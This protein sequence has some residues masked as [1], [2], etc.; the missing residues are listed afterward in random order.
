MKIFAVYLMLLFSPILLFSQ[1]ANYDE[2]KMPAYKLPELLRLKNGKEVKSSKV[3]MKKRRPEILADF[4]NEMFGKIPRTLKITSSKVLEESNKAFDG[5]ATRKQIRLTVKKGD[6]EFNIGLLLY[7]PNSTNPAPV[8]VGYNFNGN[9]TVCDDP[10][11]LLTESWIN[12]ETSLGIKNNQVTEQSRGSSTS[13]W[14][15]E[16][17]IDSGFGLA[18]VYYGDVDPD[19]NDFSDGIQPF[20]YSKGQEKPLPNQWGSIAAWSWGLSRVMDY[21]ETEKRVDPKKVIVFGHSRLGKTSLWAGATD[22]RFAIVISNN[23][24]CGGAA[25]SKRI[26]GETVARINQSFPHWF[27]NNFKKYN[28]NEADLPFDQHML[29]ALIAPRP[30]YIASAFEDKWAD[31]KGEYLSGFYA[32]PVYNLFGLEGLTS[33]EQPPINT[34][35]MNQIGYHIRDGKH[36]VTPF[37]WEQYIKF[38][39]LHLN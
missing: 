14:C 12:N 21:L 35:V 18:T 29:I 36:D 17:L 16:K 15:V 37:D 7:L 5:K 39:R 1:E 24:G 27:C 22:Q 32:T 4:E 2:S 34:P 8:F 25:L 20:L 6:K 10:N 26:Y 13:Q 31:P 19:R 30:V 28:N 3:W 33:P 9:H 38:A 11:I 23:S